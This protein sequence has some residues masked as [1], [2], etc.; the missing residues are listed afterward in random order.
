VNS[1]R[2]LASVLALVLGFG[3]GSAMVAGIRLR[4]Q[5]PGGVLGELDFF[6]YCATAYAP[7]SRAV[8]YSNDAY[9]WRC[10]VF[11]PLFSTPE[12]DPDAACSALYGVDAEARTA[13][14]ASPYR[15]RC[16]R[17]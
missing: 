7:S 4:D 12:I 6:A 9:G 14:P 8:L 16:Y 5:G 15:W 2:A 3:V 1:R 13:D 17:A 10:L 11:D